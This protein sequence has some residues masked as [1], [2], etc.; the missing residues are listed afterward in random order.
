MAAKLI[1]LDLFCGGGG[2][3]RGIL[4]AGFDEVVGIDIND[5]CKSYPGHFI[6]GDA[7][8]P[9][10]RLSDFDF[11]WASPPCQA[12]SSATR[13]A[14][15]KRKHP[16]LIQHTEKL[17]RRHPFTCIENVPGSPIRADVV[18]SGA[19]FDLPIVRKRVFQVSG[20]EPPFLLDPTHGCRSTVRGELAIVAGHGGGV[21]ARAR[22]G[23]FRAAIRTRNSA[24]GWRSAMGLGADEMTRD[25]VAQAVPPAYA[26]FIATEA[27]KQIRSQ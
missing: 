27:I 17:L 2:A 22:R 4:A 16:N 14:P 23:Q 13:T 12:F 26:E 15:L 24:S 20:F 3:A 19:M 25:E 10:V 18:C 5:H 8:K 7:L 6:L 11:V 1:A 9:P 21:N